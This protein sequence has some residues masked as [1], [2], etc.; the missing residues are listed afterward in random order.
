MKTRNHT[1]KRLPQV[2]IL[3]PTPSWLQH[4]SPLL[5]QARIFS[6]QDQEQE[7]LELALADY[8]RTPSLNALEQAFD[9]YLS[10]KQTENAKKLLKDMKQLGAS[11]TFLNLQKTVYYIV[12]EKF[13][14]AKLYLNKVSSNQKELDT[15][16]RCYFHFAQGFLSFTTDHPQTFP[17]TQALRYDYLLMPSE[18]SM[19]HVLRG[20][21]RLENE[22]YEA[23]YQDAQSALHAYTPTNDDA[24]YYLRALSGYYAGHCTHIFQDIEHCLKSKDP[25]ITKR[26]KQTLRELRQLLPNSPVIIDA[27]FSKA[28]RHYFLMLRKI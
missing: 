12:L 6:N 21:I 5:Q 24:V 3:T 23:A 17:F 14:S 19:T 2:P 8:K 1:S 27:D 22:A 15:Q 16:H 10:L 9:S 13:K 20:L 25:Q 26:M 7:A 18:L 28:L 11:E 4:Y